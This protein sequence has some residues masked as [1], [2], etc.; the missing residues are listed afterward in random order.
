MMDV[1]DSLNWFAVLECDACARLIGFVGS[2]GSM[3][4]VECFVVCQHFICAPNCGCDQN[5]ILE[6]SVIL[7]IILMSI[8]SK[9]RHFCGPAF[10]P[11]FRL[12]KWGET[13]CTHSAWTDPGAHI[14]YQIL[15]PFFSGSKQH[16]VLQYS[17]NYLF[18]NQSQGPI[19]APA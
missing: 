7:L 17:F 3:R 2:A 13:L 18:W 8:V 14:V 19:F 10:K 11:R 5:R 6:F 4:H 15:G 9:N 1:L 16:L 12:R